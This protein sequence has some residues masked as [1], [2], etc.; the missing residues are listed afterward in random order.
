M[1]KQTHKK[2]I[3]LFILAILISISCIP[4]IGSGQ[5]ERNSELEII[6]ENS[7]IDTIKISAQIPEFTFSTTEHDDEK[8]AIINLAD[9][10]FSIIDGQAKLPKIRRMVEI[11]QDATPNIIINDITWEET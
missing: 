10:G 3:A 4:M 1:K 5:Q 8:Y 7:D 6:I 11:P 9:E 2:P